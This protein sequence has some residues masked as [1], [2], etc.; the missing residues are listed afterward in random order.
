[1][2]Q[3][4]QA[5]AALT[6][7]TT[8]RGNDF[9]PVYHLAP[10]A[11]W[12]NDPNGLVFF[13]GY[14]HAFYQHHPYGVDWGPMHW[15]HATSPDMV[16]W[17]HQPIALAPDSEADRDGCFSG[18]AVEFHGQLALIYTGHC[19]LGGTGDDSQIREVQCLAL[20][21][22][23]IHFEKQGVVL[24]PPAGIMHFRDP[25]VWFEADEWW[26]VVGARD[27]QNQGQVLLYRSTCLQTWHF[28]R[29]LAAAGP[30]EGYM[31]ECPDFFALGRHRYLLC[32]PQGIEPQANKFVNLYQSG[33]I[34]GSWQPNEDFTRSSAFTELDHGH[35]FYAPQSFLAEDGRRIVMAWMDMWEAPMPSKQEGWCGSMTL[36]RQLS[37][38]GGQLIQLP[39]R[40]LASLRQSYSTLSPQLING[41]LPVLSDATAVELKLNWL[42]ATSECGLC[43]GSGLKLFYTPQ[44]R[45]LT[46][47]RDYPEYGL[48][49]RRQV[50]LDETPQM[51]WHIFIDRS[52]IE[53]FANH[54]MVVLSSR[55]YPAAT[56]RAL[57]L[58]S[59]EGNTELL[60]AHYWQLGN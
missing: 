46:L 60:D 6:K 24:T 22:D 18:S 39:I 57:S 7:L 17:T 58:Y 30:G 35:D 59:S 2:Q 12:M 20:S 37:Q 38:I 53:L 1:M 10:P 52:S 13:N 27:A 36:P 40:E 25:K 32:S 55:I 42:P 26:M 43:L 11:G 47:Q 21:K 54:G 23:G 51:H 14:Y 4:E 44:T 28:D 8:L 33:V 16:H 15:G 49:D 19:W 45:C 34:A 56:D 50:I 5:Q 48:Q 31:W 29:V 9:Y 41:I 3:L